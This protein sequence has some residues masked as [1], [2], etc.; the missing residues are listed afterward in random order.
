MEIETETLQAKPKRK[1]TRNESQ[2][3][4]KQNLTE[5]KSLPKKGKGKIKNSQEKQNPETPKKKIKNEN[6]SFSPSNLTF[7]SLEEDNLHSLKISIHFNK[8]FKIA[9]KNLFHLNWE[10]RHGSS[11]IIK[12]FFKENFGFLGFQ[13]ELVIRSSENMNKLDILKQIQ[14]ELK[15]YCENIQNKDNLISD[16]LTR[17]LIIVTL[18]RF[19]DFLFEKVIF[20]SKEKCF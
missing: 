6:N 18:D 10:K 12:A 19:G 14:Q 2:K 7:N 15:K 17:F 1:S 20:S 8:F 4:S 5:N 13:K 16:I 3:N 11:L 9:L